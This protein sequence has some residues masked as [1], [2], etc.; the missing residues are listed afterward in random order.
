MIHKM[1][2]VNVMI[3]NKLIAMLN[4]VTAGIGFGKIKMM[5]KLIF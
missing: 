4:Q 3:M 5:N 2:I 1:R